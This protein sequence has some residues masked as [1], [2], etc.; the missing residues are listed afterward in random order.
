MKTGRCIK[1]AGERGAGAEVMV[2]LGRFK[3]HLKIVSGPASKKK[4][5]IWCS[6]ELPA[7]GP[8]RGSQKLILVMRITRMYGKFNF[9][10]KT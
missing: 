4:K 6:A 5:S 2:T 7:I 3:S 8:R 10:H 1:R 9:T